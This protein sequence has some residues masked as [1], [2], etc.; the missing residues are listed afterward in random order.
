MEAGHGRDKAA[1]P[2][3]G[4]PLA[5]EVFS[6]T[7]PGARKAHRPAGKISP[8]TAGGTTSAG[9]SQAARRPGDISPTAGLKQPS[10]RRMGGRALGRRNAAPV[11]STKA[12]PV[13][14]DSPPWGASETGSTTDPITPQGLRRPQSCSRFSPKATGR[15]TRLRPTCGEGPLCGPI[16]RAVLAPGKRS[17]ASPRLI[18]LADARSVSQSLG[19]PTASQGTTSC[20]ARQRT[21]SSISDQATHD[22]DSVVRTWT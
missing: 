13:P 17:S 20:S 22:G 10:S 15:T 5:P 21:P 4:S 12:R 2:E 9:L 18:L 11:Q 7:R 14:P 19:Q 8:G 1:R 3:P 6:T 16:W